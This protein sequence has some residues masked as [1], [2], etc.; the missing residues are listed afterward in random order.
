V[1]P[2]PQKVEPT[3]IS[4]PGVVLGPR[5]CPPGTGDPAW[6][7][8]LIGTD[9]GT[10]HVENITCANI[11]GND[12]IQALVQ[13]RHLDANATL[14]LYVFTNITNN[15][16]DQLFKL[17]GLV[18]GNA[19]ISGY[20]TVLTAEVDKTSGVN[21]GKP[22]QAQTAD[23]FREFDWSPENGRLCKPPSL[24]SSLI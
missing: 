21:K 22:I 8:A 15:K 14:D 1:T 24:V 5:P 7:D 13:V 3:A 2:T 17:I 4:I 6:W 18:K 12:S 19:K 9:T 16:P 20:N 11:I 10:K 23:L